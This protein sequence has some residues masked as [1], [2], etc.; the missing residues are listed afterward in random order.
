MAS[1]RKFFFLESFIELRPKKST[2]LI[3]LIV[4][5]YS[6]SKDLP[7]KTKKV[8]VTM[9]KNMSIHDSLFSFPIKSLLRKIELVFSWK[10]SVYMLS[11]LLRTPVLDNFFMLVEGLI[12]VA[13][14]D[15]S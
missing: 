9:Q 4:A 10:Q 8:G 12:A 1:E 14:L 5:P 2:Y 3:F 11:L 13:C 7:K 6:P 15:M